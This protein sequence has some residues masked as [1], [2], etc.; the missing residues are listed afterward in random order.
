MDIDTFLKSVS[1]QDLRLPTINS[2]PHLARAPA[3][4]DAIFHLP[5]LALVTMVIARRT[6]FQTVILGRC[7][8]LLLVEHFGA[9]RRSEHGLQTSLTLRRRCAD[10]LAFLEATGLVTV[11]GDNERVVEVTKAGKAQIDSAVR[12][13]NDLGLLL[14]QLQ[15][16]QERVK[17]RIGKNEY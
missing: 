1:T 2:E 11:S 15:I 9:L 5:L 17:A 8:S 6:P 7:V 10:S 14:R 4:I 16:S 3:K 12:N 13:A